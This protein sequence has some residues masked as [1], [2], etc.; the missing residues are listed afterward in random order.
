MA[1]V[2]QLIPD[3]E[4]HAPKF[5]TLDTAG[6]GARVPC[7][8]RHITTAKTME[9]KG[10]N[11]RLTKQIQWNR[12]TNPME[13]FNKINGFA[14]Q[15]QWIRSMK[16]ALLTFGFAGLQTENHQSHSFILLQT[17]SKCFQITRKNQRLTGT[18][19]VFIDRHIVGL[20]GR[21]M[22]IT[23]GS[24][25]THLKQSACKAK[26]KQPRAAPWVLWSRVTNALQGQKHFPR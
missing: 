9:G 5:H 22:H 15:N 3:T 19:D 1:G 10:R 16:T 18:Q 11:D 21:F 6:E 2:L 24:S 4:A 20:A 7:H 14:E 13:S 12:S 17:C 26:S 23:C 25:Y 8:K